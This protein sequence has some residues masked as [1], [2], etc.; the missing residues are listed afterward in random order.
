MVINLAYYLIFGLILF[1]IINYI[2][3]KD[4]SIKNFLPII[5]I[6]IIII[7]GIIAN[8]DINTNIFLVVVVEFFIRLIS[9]LLSN[10]NDDNLRFIY[11]YVLYIL[12]SLIINNVFINKVDN[13]FLGGESLKIVVWI[14]IILY[15]YQNIK[16]IDN[17][18]IIEEKPIDNSKYREY[19]VESLKQISKHLEE[20]GW[21]DRFMY[22]ISDEPFAW[23]PNIIKQ[24][25]ALCDAIH[26]G[27]P[28]MKIYCST[29]KY[30][31]KWVGKLDIWGVGAQGQASE[32]EI[33]LLKDSGADIITTTDGHFVLDNPYNAL[34]RLMPLYCYKY[35]FVSKSG[36][37]FND[38]NLILLTLAD[39]YK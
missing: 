20:K 5:L 28:K 11:E 26:E 18:V 32:N 31:P 34:E 4:K 1:F 25:I 16:I 13:I 24:M 30:V 22:Y 10:D 9:N 6:Y 38:D 14:L 21:T 12:M 8:K 2:K 35:G 23:H 39:I 7:S 15:L 17:P 37:K 3:M 27:A 29:W 36:F 33:K 19:I